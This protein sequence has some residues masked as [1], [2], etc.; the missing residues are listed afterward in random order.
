MGPRTKEFEEIFAH[1][2]GVKHAFAVTNGTAELH[3]ACEALGFEAGDEVLCPA[4]TF[5]A[6]ANAILYTGARPGY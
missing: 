5:V 6:S 1:F 3:L 4:P 2:L